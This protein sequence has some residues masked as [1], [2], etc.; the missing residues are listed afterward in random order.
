MEIRKFSQY[1]LNE[2]LNL[3]TL[4]NRL[5]EDYID[6]KI[7]I[8]TIIN[9]TLEEISDESV[10]N[11]DLKS[12]IND[13]LTKGKDSNTIISLNEDND[14]FN[15]YL[16][17]K[18]DVDQ[19]LNVTEYLDK[20]PKDNNV[21]SLYDVVIDGTKQGIIEILKIIKREI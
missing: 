8:I 5:S 12:F 14:I 13:Y 6:L 19:L 20:S 11:N 1:S 21:F 9:T 15:F 17:N 2:N 7:D 10:K 16:K 18:S 4:R 3:D